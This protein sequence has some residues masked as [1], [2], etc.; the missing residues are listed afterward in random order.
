MVRKLVK[1]I[2]YSLW[3]KVSQE[4]LEIMTIVDIWGRYKDIVK[5]E[6]KTTNEKFFSLYSCTSPWSSLGPPGSH[7]NGIVKLQLVGHRLTHITESLRKEEH[8]PKLGLWPCLHPIPL[9]PTPP[10]VK[11]LNCSCCKSNT[12]EACADL[13]EMSCK[14]GRKGTSLAQV[15]SRVRYKLQEKEMVNRKVNF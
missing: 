4:R 10:V 11:V 7:A 12:V 8:L 1:A 6:N 15:S 2:C 9:H 5:K 3:H 14:T 13:W